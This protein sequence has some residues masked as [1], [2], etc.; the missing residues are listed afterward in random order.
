MSE[1]S[2]VALGRAGGEPRQTGPAA[3][4]SEA[5]EIALSASGSLVLVGTPIGNLGDLAAR[6]VAELRAADLVCCEDTRRTGL[7]LARLGLGDVKL[8][9]VD[10]HTEAASAAAVCGLL[11]AGRRVVLV[12]DA[13]M[14]AV[15]DPGAR[16]VA[17][18]ARAGHA[19][20]VVPG[21][22]AC[23]AALAVSGFEAGRHVFEGFLPRKGAA[24]AERLAEIAAERRTVVIFESPHRLHVCLGDLAAA[25]GASRR[26]VVA[27][28][29]TKLHEEVRR[30]TL[31]ELAESPQRPERGEV[32]I[33]VE[34][35]ARRADDPG[36]AD[37]LSSAQG[38]IV[39]GVSRRD[40]AARTAALHGV[41]RRRVYELLIRSTR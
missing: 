24:R 25:C 15:S 3:A 14:P 17:S 40:A 41:A 33:V 11:A 36:D 5:S 1:A 6:A 21:P 19:V 35:A 32:V 9:R 39:E 18:C 20:T 37:L 10:R 29:L 28:E 16:L 30:G 34:G 31:Q 12:S 4:L 13:G 38:M 23:L 7:L 22:S 27:R 26:A 2:D 8:R